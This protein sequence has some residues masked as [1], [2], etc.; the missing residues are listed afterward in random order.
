[1]PAGWFRGVAGSKSVGW[2]GMHCMIVTA[3]DFR[4]IPTRSVHR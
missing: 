3:D 4:A 1:M 2:K